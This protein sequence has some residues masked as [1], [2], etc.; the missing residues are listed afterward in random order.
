MLN[1]TVCQ[2]MKQRVMRNEGFRGAVYKDTVG[3]STIGYGRNLETNGITHEEARYLLNNDLARCEDLLAKS[4]TCYNDL[5]DIR[6]SV[7]I[8]LAFNMGLHN[9]LGFTNMWAALASKH[10][11]AA[12]DALLDSKAARQ[13]PVRYA[14]LAKILLTGILP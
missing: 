4:K 13:L 10:W 8:E 6:K 2:A 11:G 9:L 12:K 5:D 7:L 3:I 1:A 14:E